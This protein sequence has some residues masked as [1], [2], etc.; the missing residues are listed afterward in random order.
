MYQLMQRL[1]EQTNCKFM[2]KP[3][4]ENEFID[5][6]PLFPRLKAKLGQENLELLTDDSQ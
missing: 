6:M 4:V 2:L 3:M 1:Q 5:M